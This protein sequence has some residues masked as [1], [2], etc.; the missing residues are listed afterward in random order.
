[1][2]RL[3]IACL[4]LP[5]LVPLAR[6][7][8]Q[9]VDRARTESQ[10]AGQA[11]E[12][13]RL[14]KRGEW[15]PAIALYEAERASRAALGDIR[16]EAYAL[17]AIGCCK[18]E[19]GDDEGAI[20][21]LAKAQVLD[22]KREDKG[23]AGYDLFLIARAEDRLGRLLDS[24]KTLEKALPMLSTAIDRDHEADARLYL[25]RILLN[26][27][28]AEEARPHVDR[29][30]VLAEEL[31]ENLRI[32]DSWAASGQI[33]GAL[34]N[35]SLAL[36]RFADA[37][38]LFE[39]EGRAAE[40][41]WMETISG[42]TLALMGRPDLALARFEE[43]ARRHEHLEDGGSLAEDLS[44]IA[45]LQLDFNRPDEALAAAQKAVEKAQEVDDR[46]REVE[47]RVRLSQVQGRK[48]DWSAAAETLDEAVILIR[49]VYRDEPFEQI[50]L[51]LTA[52]ATD[53][54]AKLDHKALERLELA[55]KIAE[56]S[57]QPALKAIVA[58][59]RQEFDNRDKPPVPPKPPGE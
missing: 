56:D 58:E 26:L 23:Y 6:S 3:V 28:R 20:E 10:A 55:K 57:N 11:A 45:G 27:G 14:F 59:A 43:A 19:L 16:Y 15:E 47:A 54:R 44:A 17:R 40:A 49:Q 18:A 46:P 39:Q 52:A 22:L 41:A 1:M 36:E 21:A 9:E 30:M 7:D 51:I 50:R 34:G 8:A 4:I 35:L 13:D 48:G 31:K 24:I 33:E 38:N 25:S 32:C 42:S 12:A 5:G 2:I 37:E 53:H 29:A